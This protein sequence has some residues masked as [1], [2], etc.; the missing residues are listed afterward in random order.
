M[1]K[2]K[3][4]SP[5]EQ[6]ILSVFDKLDAYTHMQRKRLG[7]KQVEGISYATFN[8]RVFASVID[9]IISFVLLSPILLGVTHMLGASRSGHPLDS[10]PNGA[11]FSQAVGHILSAAPIGLLLLDYLIHFVVFGVVILWCWNKGGATPGKWLLRMRIVD[12]DTL[13]TLSPRQAI[14]RYCGYIPSM[15]PLTGGFLWIMID[16]K[17]RSWHDHI[18]GTAVIKVKHWRFKDDGTTPHITVTD[19]ES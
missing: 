12:A 11:S 8:D 1:D 17:C 10:V 5:I 18:A 15:L 19:T 4:P 3:A 2:K 9:I 13:C 14:K 6:K 7:T 16:K